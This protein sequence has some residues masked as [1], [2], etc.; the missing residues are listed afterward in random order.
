[1]PHAYLRYLLNLPK[2]TVETWSIWQ[3]NSS[4]FWKAAR[5]SRIVSSNKL[6]GEYPDLRKQTLSVFLSIMASLLLPV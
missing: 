3:H 5:N 2:T 4:I 1:M 6:S